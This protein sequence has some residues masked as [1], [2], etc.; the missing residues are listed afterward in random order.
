MP[1]SCEPLTDEQLDLLDEYLL[2][3]NL[4]EEALD[5]IALHGYLCALNVSPKPMTETEWLTNVLAENP[6]SS[7]CHIDPAMLDL[8]RQENNYIRNCLESDIIVDLPCDLTLELD[9]EGDCLLEYWALCFME[10]VF[11]QEDA[12]F[13]QHEDIVAES[14]LPFMLTAN[15]DEDKELAELRSEPKFC[16]QLC[17]QIP[18]LVQDLFLL[19]RV[20]GDKPKFQKGFNGKSGPKKGFKKRHH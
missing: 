18:E 11:S 12:W 15:L 6:L 10:V 16:Q 8:M 20:P 17:E 7:A 4:K 13:E 19:F 1:Y 9:E 14:L 5:Y 2:S 3:D